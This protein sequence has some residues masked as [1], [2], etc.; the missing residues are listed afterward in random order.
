MSS[1]HDAG[2]EGEP[3]LHKVNSVELANQAHDLVLRAL[4]NGHRTGLSSED[5]NI[6]NAVAS[7]LGVVAGRQLPSDPRELPQLE[8]LHL[9]DDSEFAPANR[10]EY[11]AIE[12]LIRRSK[13]FDTT[14]EQVRKEVIPLVLNHFS[15]LKLAV[16]T[17]DDRNLTAMPVCSG[18][19]DPV[20]EIFSRSTVLSDDPSF[21]NELRNAIN[22]QEWAVYF[23]RTDFSGESAV[24]ANS[25]VHNY[26]FAE[27]G[28][29]V[30]GGRCVGDTE[31][32]PFQSENEKLVWSVQCQKGYIGRIGLATD[33]IDKNIWDAAL[34]LYNQDAQ[35]H[36]RIYPDGGFRFDEELTP[37]AILGRVQEYLRQAH[38]GAK[39]EEPRFARKLLARL[40][41]QASEQHNAG[42]PDIDIVEIDID[43]EINN[44]LE[45]NPV[46]ERA[47][48]KL[49]VDYRQIVD[50]AGLSL[51]QN[52][53]IKQAYDEMK[54]CSQIEWQNANSLKTLPHLSDADLELTPGYFSDFYRSYRAL[55]S[56]QKLNNPSENDLQAA[57]ILRALDSGLR[58]RMEAE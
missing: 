50:V 26:K 12:E 20:R 44:F 37:Y 33:E 36:L 56:C 9:P 22:S 10:T 46:I 49:D 13:A 47:L 11:S 45:N 57:E 19:Q 54:E 42:I 52:Q 35:Q 6:L 51:S 4:K 58:E 15:Y 32:Q 1:N 8:N 43:G 34:T 24:K 2:I 21:A 53:W 38:V 40:K 30:E 23:V 55:C 3:E 18:V 48:N 25:E 14:Y 39:K 28:R 27:F 41:P 17:G 29:V 16:Q 5:R 31:L 7:L